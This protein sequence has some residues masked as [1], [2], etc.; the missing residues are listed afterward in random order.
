MR[1]TCPA[2]LNLIDMITLIILG[3]E[4]NLRS[5][6]CRTIDY[7]YNLAGEGSVGTAASREERGNHW[8]LRLLP[9]LISPPLDL[10][11]AR[12]ISAF[13]RVVNAV[14]KV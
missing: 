10:D 12:V 7:V 4:Y 2:H 13:V 1:A 5:S 14:E 8:R 3:E 6:L 9:K 11:V